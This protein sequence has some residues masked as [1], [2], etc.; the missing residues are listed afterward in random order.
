MVCSNEVSCGSVHR[1][2]LNA[3]S[4]AASTAASCPRCSHR[5]S[6]A[7]DERSVRV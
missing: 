3:I 7:D 5:I 1:R 6:M 2:C 4:T